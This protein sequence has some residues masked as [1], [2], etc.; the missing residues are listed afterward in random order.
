M[1]L[2]NVGVQSREVLLPWEAN[3]YQLISWWEMEKFAAEKFCNICSNLA[4]LSTRFAEASRIGS[5]GIHPKDMQWMIG[6]LENIENNCK[7][8]GLD[9]SAIQLQKAVKNLKADADGSSLHAMQVSQLLVD[10][11]TVIASEMSTKLFMRI[12][13]ERVAFYEQDD[14]FGANVA[15]NFGSAKK[16]IKSAGS[17]YAADR[18]T[19]CV[20]HL[21]RVLEVGLNTLAKELGVTFDRRSWDNIINDIEAEI[22][23]INGPARGL[24]WKVKQQFYSEAAKDFRYFKDAW[25]NHAMHYREHYEASEAKG[26]LDHIKS[27]MM[28]LADNGLK[29]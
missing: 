8:I 25:R 5:T 6:A 4:G 3:P 26:I 12:F 19:A 20:M 18:N 22:Q 21:M 27:F 7:Y 23:K 16:D 1:A 11:G 28:H 29:E 13:P 14:L 15:A 24:N 9:V 2:A 10:L 17:C